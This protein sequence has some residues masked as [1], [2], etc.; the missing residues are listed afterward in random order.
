MRDRRTCTR[1]GSRA[2]VY[3]LERTRSNDWNLPWK[4][5]RILA[6][7]SS[8][9]RNATFRF[10]F[11]QIYRHRIFG[12]RQ[13]LTFHR[14]WRCVRN[15]G[16]YERFHKS[17]RPE[18][19]KDKMIEINDR[20]QFDTTDRLKSMNCRKRKTFLRISNL[21]NL[22]EKPQSDDAWR[23]GLGEARLRDRGKAGKEGTT[24]VAKRGETWQATARRNSTQP[25]ETREDNARVA[26]WWGAVNELQWTR[27]EKGKG[28]GAV[29]TRLPPGGGSSAYN[30]AL[31][32]I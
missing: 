22:R 31:V 19:E 8:R 16:R 9:W 11:L 25:K 5:Q 7:R 14:R 4:A 18:P 12:A 20:R 23:C 1:A 30:R 24:N 28:K 29:P 10:H 3:G 26:D 21:M 13:I 27:R 32:S 15:N 17:F 2:T 6:S